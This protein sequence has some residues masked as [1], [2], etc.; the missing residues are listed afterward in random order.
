MNC[1][2]AITILRGLLANQ[3]SA[4]GEEID[5]LVKLGLVVESDPYTLRYLRDIDLLTAESHEF[6]HEDGDPL[7]PAGIRAALA[8]VDKKLKNDWYRLRTSSEAL[9]A[10]EDNRVSLRR[11]LGVMSDPEAGQLVRKAA[12]DR[13]LI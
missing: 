5:E 7:S 2:R 4:D 9:K 12:R 1:G 11:A 8:D 3:L 6:F 10:Q 13:A